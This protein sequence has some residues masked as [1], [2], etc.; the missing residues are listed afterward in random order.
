MNCR[1]IQLIIR[2]NNTD[3]VATT[4]V[5]QL[6]IIGHLKNLDPNAITWNNDNVLDASSVIAWTA[7]MPP[8]TFIKGD[9]LHTMTDR[10]LT[11]NP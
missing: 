8:T 3:P 6:A 5:L 4:S 7:T 11:L 9:Q 1:T 10:V 2:R